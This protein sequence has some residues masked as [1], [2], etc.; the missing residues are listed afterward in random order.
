MIYNRWGDLLYQGSSLD[1]GW[2]VK[3]FM[4][5]DAPNGTYFFL[6][7]VEADNSAVTINFN[8]SGYLSLF[9]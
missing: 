7:E 4:G 5:E 8:N 2:N 9:R 3:N 6:L 1:E